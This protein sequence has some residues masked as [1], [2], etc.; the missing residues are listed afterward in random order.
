[1]VDKEAPDFTLKG[2][3]G[4]EVKLSEH[5]GKVILLHFF[6]TFSKASGKQLPQMEKLHQDYNDRGLVV[7]GVTIEKD[8]DKLREFAAQNKLSYP[9]M[10]DAREVFRDYKLG[11]I[12]DVC[13]INRD[14]AV[15]SMYLGYNPC[16]EEEIRAEVD[17]LLKTISEK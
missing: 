3:D 9:I 10:L 12:P 13:L 6:A 8:L 14:F 2:L 17:K 4:K 7:I 15:S 5:K 11:Q 16:K 1:M